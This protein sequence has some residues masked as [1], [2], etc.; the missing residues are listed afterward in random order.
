[1]GTTPTALHTVGLPS[2]TL[3]YATYG[4]EGSRYP[5][6]LFVHGAVVDHRLWE[7]VADLLADRGIR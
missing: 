4:P 7:P 3:E 6:V 2:G 1:M 5:P